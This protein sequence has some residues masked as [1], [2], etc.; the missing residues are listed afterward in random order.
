MAAAE[1]A[2]VPSRED[3]ALHRDTLLGLWD[4]SL[5]E[6]AHMRAKFEWFYGSCPNGKPL[7]ELLWHEPSGEWVGACA[8]G[9]RRMAYAGREI[10]AGVLVD[11][12]VKPLH[13][14]LGPAL[15]MQIAMVDQV[16]EELD[17]LLGFPNPRAAA[18]FKRIRYAKFRDIV[19][20]VRVLRHAPYL[21]RRVPPLL[22]GPCGWL[23]DT[24]VRMRDAL[25]RRPLRPLR[26]EWS[27][28][29]DPRMGDLWERTRPRSMLTAWRSLDFLRWRFDASPLPPARHLLVFGPGGGDGSDRLVAWFTVVREGHVLHVRDFWSVDAEA[30]T[31]LACVDALLAAAWKAGAAAVS[32]EMA[33]SAPRAANWLARGFVARNARPVFG[34][35]SAPPNVV[36]E[37]TDVHL[38]AVDEDE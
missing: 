3:P 18:L 33:T 29:V 19:R 26:T 37:D 14:S 15:T 8:A 22:A 12:V 11:L 4:G 31:P 5:G 17:L 16:R 27:D 36:G 30:G 25:R 7:L 35:W 38:T 34:Y 28:H 2:Y 10:A 13:R 6:P 23:L 1:A 32:V 9:R 20:Y 24:A 21:Q